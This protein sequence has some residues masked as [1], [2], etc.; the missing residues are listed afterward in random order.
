MPLLGISGER[1]RHRMEIICP[2]VHDAGTT[3]PLSSH[4]TW[5]VV[6]LA[7][8]GVLMKAM[9]MPGPISPRSHPVDRRAVLR[10]ALGLGGGVA[11]ACGGLGTGMTSLAASPLSEAMPGDT[12]A[13]LPSATA[14]PRPPKP[15][16]AGIPYV[17]N[18]GSKQTLDIYLPSSP[19]VP[20]TP[21]RGSAAKGAMPIVVWMH[22]GGWVGGEKHV[23]LPYLLDEGYA[24]VSIDYRL[25]QDAMFP[26][27]IVDANA[28]V[29]W[30]WHHA[31]EYG[32]DRNRLVVAGSSAGGRSASIVAT[33]ANDQ[34][35]D[36]AADPEMRIA[37]L[38]DFF[39]GTESDYELAH[40]PERTDLIE[41]SLTSEE[42]AE[43]KRLIDVRTY[44]DADDPPTLIVHGDRDRTVPIAESEALVA[45]MQDAGVPVT[46]AEM[47]GRGHGLEHYQD[48]A[49]QQIVRTFLSETLGSA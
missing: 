34:I 16:F 13:A 30:V 7:L 37:A 15:S 35:A 22:G 14:H 8:E 3:V 46:F 9:A 1:A 33:S 42:I 47:P 39:G 19:P 49:V 40:N 36:F 38:I 26:A 2:V 41:A 32:F 45:S 31:A 25:L 28:A 17:V 18:G 20:G 43:M 11:M 48:D 5:D 24:I 12:H 6:E 29:A 4:R 10:R 23:G 21:E 44:V 27:Q